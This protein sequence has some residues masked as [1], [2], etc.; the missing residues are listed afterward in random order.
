MSVAAK[1][2]TFIS[3]AELFYHFA[4][5]CFRAEKA[6]RDS[7]QQVDEPY[8]Q[9]LELV[10][11]VQHA[12]GE[13]LEKHAEKGPENL[14]STRLQYTPDQQLEPGAGSAGTAVQDI[15]RVNGELLQVL[16]DV[17]EKMSPE[18]IREM[19]GALRAEV[20]SFNRKIS[21][22]RLSMQDV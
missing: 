15:T 10:A 14:I 16:Q 2:E 22:I 9:G 19:V 12:L 21:M 5:R 17:E 1:R 7:M 13:E 18:S 6:L 20:D 8:R 11:Q 3:C 4:E